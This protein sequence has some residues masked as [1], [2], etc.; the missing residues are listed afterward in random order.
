ML[1]ILAIATILVCRLVTIACNNEDD[2][3]IKFPAICFFPLGNLHIS[4]M[5][6]YSTILAMSLSYLYYNMFKV[7][8]I[9]EHSPFLEIPFF[10]TWVLNCAVNKAL[11]DLWNGSSFGIYI[12]LHGLFCIDPTKCPVNMYFQRA[13]GMTKNTCM[14]TGHK[15]GPMQNKPCHNVFIIRLF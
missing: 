13:I 11:H 12:I 10:I 7:E 2:L 1:S 15:W 14:L 6:W 5:I 4:T 8:V 3:S 9:F